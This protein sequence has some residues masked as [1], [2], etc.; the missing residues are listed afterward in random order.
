M[1]LFLCTTQV[2]AAPPLKRK[3]SNIPALFWFRGRMAMLSYPGAA[4]IGIHPLL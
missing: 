4:G 1:L 3:A 2:V